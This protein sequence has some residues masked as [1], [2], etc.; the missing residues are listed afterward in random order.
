VNGTCEL[1]DIYTYQDETNQL[2]CKPCPT[3]YT[4]RQPGGT[5]ISDCQ[6]GTLSST[7]QTAFSHFCNLYINGKF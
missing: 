4:T 5:D 6:A 3:D 2:S 7:K 1:C